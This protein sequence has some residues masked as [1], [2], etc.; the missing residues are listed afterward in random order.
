M[1]RPAAIAIARRR[2]ADGRGEPPAVSLPPPVVRIV[3]RRLA[4]RAGVTLVLINA[5]YWSNVAPLARQQMRRWR[6]RAL[7]IDDPLL[8]TLALAKLDEEGF[9]AEAAAMLATLAPRRHRRQ[10]VEAIVAAEIL[11]DYLDGLTESPASEA[12][13]DGERLFT[14]FTDAVTP[15]AEAGGDYYRDHSRSEEVYLGE[16]VACV[17]LGFGGLPASAR[18]AGTLARSAARGARAQLH[19]HASGPAQSERLQ[20]WAEREA[21][22]TS[23]GWREFLAGS[24]CSVLAVHA[25][26]AAASDHR[27]THEQALEID[28]IYL[29]ISVLPTILDSLIDH[30]QDAQAGLPGYVRHYGDRDVLASRLADVIEDAV[31]H[32]RQATHG[33][34]HV[35]TLVGVV[36]YYASAPT[37]DSE[38]ARPIIEH[39]GARLQPLFAPSLW[40]MRGWRAV[41]RLRTQRRGIAETGVRGA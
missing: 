37:A 10:T 40:L 24:A 9:N 27:T 25:L 21:A 6:D 20:C 38:L 18:V 41:K 32:S 29:L 17:R 4:L 1:S 7:A 8:R 2:R 35:M 11:Y 31:R 22:G 26:I 14:A 3:G 28:R 13:G 12:P 33:A 23:L 39:I 36:A 5:R 34:R 16:L 30:E 15:W 19:I